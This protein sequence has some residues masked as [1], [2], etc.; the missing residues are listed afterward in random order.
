MHFRYIFKQYVLKSTECDSSHSP[1]LKHIHHSI[2]VFGRSFNVYCLYMQQA[3]IH[4]HIGGVVGL[5]TSRDPPGEVGG[6]VS[7]PSPADNPHEVVVCV[8][9]LHI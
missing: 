9:P 3:Y 5:V 2:H 1:Q 8:C 6:Y 4:H 7:I